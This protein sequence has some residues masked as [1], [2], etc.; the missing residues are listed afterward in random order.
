MRLIANTCRFLLLAV[1]LTVAQGALAQDARYTNLAATQQLTN[2]ALTGVIPGGFQFT[3]NYRE[4]YT[5]VLQAEGYRSYAAGVQ[6]RRRAGRNNY[7]GLGAQL[8]RD[9]A[10]SSDFQRTQGLLSL[11]YQQRLSGSARRGI[12]QYLAGGAQVGYAQRGFDVT[13]L[14]FSNQYFVDN[15]TREAYLDRT[16]PTGEEFSGSGAG[17]YL[18]V[19]AGLAWYGNFGDRL[20][21]YAGVAAYHLNSPNVSP[22][23]GDSD[24]LDRRYVVHGGGEIPLGNGY[25]SLLPAMRIMVQGPALDALLGGYVRYS[26]RRWREIAL[27][28]G[29]FLQGS[30]QS[31]DNLK[32]NA[33]IVG[34]GLETERVQFVVN[35][36]IGVGDLN[37]VTNGRAGWELGVIYQQGTN[38]RSKVVCPKF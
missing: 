31:S 17:G 7:F 23:P 20:G 14:W 3:A 36:D 37:T 27:R 18:D 13:K 19:N 11:S 25:M 30:N 5:S 16:L 15:N 28:A 22:F 9:E 21:A 1:G 33:V 12:G 38:Y 32:P 6:F 4:L 10:G 26:Q 8:Q 29:L 2:P 24:D 35:Y 34:V